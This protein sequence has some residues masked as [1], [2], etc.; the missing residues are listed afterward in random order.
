MRI[1]RV[2]LYRIAALLVLLPAAATPA[3]PLIVALSKPFIAITTGFTG[4]DI[5]LFGT[6]G[7]EADLIV[8][9][10]GPQ[11]RLPV[12]RKERQFGIWIN[13]AEMIF[14]D[15]PAFYLVAATKP[16]DQL[17]P[18]AVAAE[19]G[20]GERFLPLTVV[21]PPRPP[22]EIAAFR[23]ALIRIKQR[24]GLYATA[25]VPVMSLGSGLF[26]VDM[27]IPANAPIGEYQVRTYRINDGHVIAL[28]R[29]TLD[30]RKAG[31]EAAISYFAQHRG[32]AYG[33]LATVFAAVA[34]WFASLLFRKG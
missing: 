1:G 17:L 5:L 11:N 27:M 12:R 15:V 7:S 28:E 29:N 19:N 31:M 18:D 6:T 24:S 26:R 34:G 21:G 30:V 2:W 10:S 25:E 3:P 14:D 33:V 20:I 16:V 13:A 4:S 22:E 23:A 9:V 32:F 8:V